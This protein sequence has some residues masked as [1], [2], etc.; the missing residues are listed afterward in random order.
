MNALLRNNA[1]LLGLLLVTVAMTLGFRLWTPD[2]GGVLLD[3]LASPDEAR[4]LLSSLSDSQVRT[5]I[6]LTLG[7]DMLYPFAYGGLFVGLVLLNFQGRLGYLLTLPAVI[8][9]PVDLAE[10]VVHLAALYGTD[11][12]L[13]WKALLTPAKFGLIAISASFALVGYLMRVFRYSGSETP[14]P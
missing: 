11:T 13:D 7:L 12:Y 3:S 4:A 8:V 10:N 1:T 14:P 2:V 9:I 5:H 6:R